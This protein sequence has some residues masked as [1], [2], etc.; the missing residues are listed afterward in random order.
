M[1]SSIPK[2]KFP[3]SEKFLKKVSHQLVCNKQQQSAMPPPSAVSVK[4]LRC[5]PRPRHGDILART[6]SDLP[7][8]QLVLL[9]LQSSLQNL[10]SL[11]TSDGNVDGNLLVSSDTERSDGVSGFGRD[12]GLTGKLL[13]NLGS[14]SKSVTGFSDRDVCR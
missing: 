10:L 8:S 4:S 11:G 13:E 14:S 12:G 3:V 6:E 2:P 5:S 7:L 1:C 9:D